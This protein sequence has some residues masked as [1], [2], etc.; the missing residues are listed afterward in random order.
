MKF[1]EIKNTEDDRRSVYINP[2]HVVSLRRSP[3]PDH[4][5]ITLS[6]AQQVEINSDIDTVKRNI[7]EAH[8]DKK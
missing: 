7:E 1:I 5:T 2:H 4:V 3:S 8:K 6:N